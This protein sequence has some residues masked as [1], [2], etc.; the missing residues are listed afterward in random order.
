MLVSRYSGRRQEAMEKL[1]ATNQVAPAAF[2]GAF[3]V[4][5]VNTKVY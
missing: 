4:L 5:S 3:I 2:R 1:K